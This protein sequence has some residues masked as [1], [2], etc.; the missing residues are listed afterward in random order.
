MTLRCTPPM[1][2][3]C[4]TVPL[5]IA[6]LA[7]PPLAAACSPGAISRKTLDASDIVAIG[8]VRIIERD[9]RNEGDANIVSGMGELRVSREIRNR[10]GLVAPFRFR[11]ER[12][13]E[14]GCIFGSAPSDG[15]L[16]KMYLQRAAARSD[17]LVIVYA[18]LQED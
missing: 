1:R 17:E 13:R 3:T 12:I 6:M 9:E 15:A 14:D 10:T 4:L 16:V 11:F 18:E 2:L 7:G 5:L 8:T